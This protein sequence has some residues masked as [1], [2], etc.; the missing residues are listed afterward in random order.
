MLSNV[1][2]AIIQ[3]SSL[4]LIVTR[5]EGRK[6]IILILKMKLKILRL[7]QSQTTTERKV[8]KS[9]PHLFTLK[10]A[11]LSVLDTNHEYKSS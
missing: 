4:V 1:H 9:N 6:D 2:V 8:W 10:Q 3:I 7:S 5:N 11:S